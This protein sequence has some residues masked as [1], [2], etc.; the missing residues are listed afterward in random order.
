MAGGIAIE[1]LE[2]FHF[3]FEDIPSVMKGIYT[4]KNIGMKKEVK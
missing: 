2:K 1:K 4:F 3:A